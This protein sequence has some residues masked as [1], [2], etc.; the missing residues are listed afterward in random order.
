[1]RLGFRIVQFVDG[2][3]DTQPNAD[4]ILPGLIEQAG[5]ADV[6]EVSVIRTG[7][8]SISLYRATRPVSGDE[9]NR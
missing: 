4:G 9:A 1:M 5:F 7:T 6:A 2:K 3:R 8:G